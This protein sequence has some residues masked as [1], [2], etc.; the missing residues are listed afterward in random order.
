[1]IEMI[2]TDF[3]EGKIYEGKVI[4]IKELVHL[5]SLLQAKKVWFISLRFQK[6]ELIV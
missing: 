3:G 1:M 2:V 6:K 5:S 4:A